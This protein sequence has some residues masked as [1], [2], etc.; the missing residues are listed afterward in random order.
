M[1]ILDFLWGSRKR[2]SAAKHL[3]DRVDPSFDRLHAMIHA[4]GV[5]MIGKGYEELVARFIDCRILHTEELAAFPA[6]DRDALYRLV[7]ELLPQIAS[8]H[9][10]VREELDR[11]RRE[12]SHGGLAEA[13]AG[14]GLRALDLLQGRDRPKT[15]Q[16]R[17]FRIAL[18]FDV[19]VACR[20]IQSDL[21]HIAEAPAL[22]W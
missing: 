18:F 4:A 20:D 16:D 1:A 10:E 11:V 5:A 7:S 6:G 17:L 13:A 12:W 22:F 9:A 2:R 15:V 8:V 3:L 19:D 21:R 14:G